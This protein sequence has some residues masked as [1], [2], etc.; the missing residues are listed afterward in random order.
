M[1]SLLSVC[2]RTIGR[3]L[4][5]LERC[6]YI[7]RRA[8]ASAKSG[9]TIGLQIELTEVTVPFWAKSSKSQQFQGGH[10]RP[11]SNTQFYSDKAK[12]EKP[13]IE[14]ALDSLPE[15]LASMLRRLRPAPG[16]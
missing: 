11:P 1:A 12:P 6:G 7:S 8:V 2:T 5:D 13:D 4:A 15:P 9:M 10:S 14:A 16:T 3:W